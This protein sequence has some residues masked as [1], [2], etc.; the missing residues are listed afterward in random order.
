MDSLDEPN[1]QSFIV[2]VWVED[3]AEKNG[4]GV[5][6]GHITHVPDHERHYLKNLGEVEDFIAPHLEEMGV[7]LRRRWRLK[8]WLKHLMEYS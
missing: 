3:S 6:H 4:R 2:K 1:A 7:K 5:W 8:S